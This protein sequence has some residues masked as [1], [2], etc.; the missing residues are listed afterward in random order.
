M[1]LTDIGLFSVENA[2][3]SEK[4]EG[5]KNHLVCFIPVFGG[6]GQSYLGAILLHSLSDTHSSNAE[7]GILVLSL[8][9]VKNNKL[10]LRIGGAFY[11]SLV[12]FALKYL[13]HLCKCASNPV[14]IWQAANGKKSL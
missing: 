4:E 14:N 11:M 1:S 7:Q 12:N 13:H 9:A 8:G 3:F 2:D 6:S 5:V 10:H